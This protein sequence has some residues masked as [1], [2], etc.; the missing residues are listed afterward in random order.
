MDRRRFLA[1]AA[2]GL[3]GLAGCAAPLSGGSAAT[4]A[5]ATATATATG[6]DTTATAGAQ[7][8][9]GVDLPVPEDELVRAG[10]KDSIAAILRPA[11]ADDWSGLSLDAGDRI[12]EPRLADGDV[13]V[14]VERGGTARAYPLRVLNYHEVVND[15]LGG[16]LLVTYCSACASGV[17]A[18][19]RVDEDTIEFGVSGYLFRSNLVMYDATT[20]SLW[21]QLAATAI[22]GARTGTRL[23][24]V[25]SATT[26]WRAWTDVH[27]DTEVL[28]PPPESTTITGGAAP[29]L[30]AGDPLGDAQGPTSE[31]RPADG[32]QPHPKTQVVG[33]VAGG[34]AKAYPLP[35]VVAEGPVNDAVGGRPVVV[36]VA[37]DDWTLVAYDR[38]VDGEALTFG[39]EGG[40]LAAGG[41]RWEV[42]TG[43]AVDG[44]HEGTRLADAAARSQLFWFTWHDFHPDTAVYTGG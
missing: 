43:E 4:P 3:G 24:L 20:D 37:K 30:Y 31:R 21:S 41:S 44:P 14:G 9:A 39:A 28:L 35:A 17:T 19:R 18:R 15:A 32:G 10:A 1:G 8:V 13:V 16:P 38:R 23:D 11:F 26:T 7:S 36:A 29:R 5:P 2:A 40:H 34:A 33:V 22:R 12:L 25:P 6:G 27:P 42:L